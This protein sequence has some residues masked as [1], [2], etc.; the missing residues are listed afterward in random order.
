M[1]QY[2]NVILR[3]L[4]ENI[5]ELQADFIGEGSKNSSVGCAHRPRLQR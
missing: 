4:P 1:P 3:L 5:T 2:T